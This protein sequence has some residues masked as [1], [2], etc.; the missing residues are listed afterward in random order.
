MIISQINYPPP[1]TGIIEDKFHFDIINFI[2]A[3]YTHENT[4]NNFSNFDIALI[5]KDSAEVARVL[6]F[7]EKLYTETKNAN[8][9]ITKHT[10]MYKKLRISYLSSEDNQQFFRDNKAAAHTVA[11]TVTSTGNKGF[12]FYMREMPDAR[13]AF[14]FQIIANVMF[15]GKEPVFYSKFGKTLIR[16]WQKIKIGEKEQDNDM[17]R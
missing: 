7:L 2:L 10:S 5:P 1:F 16:S 9:K 14:T 6:D 15:Y 3:A 8:K 12:G 11:N 17:E 4:Y 13:L